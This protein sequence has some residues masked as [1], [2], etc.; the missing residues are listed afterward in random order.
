MRLHACCNIHRCA[1][2]P[3]ALENV[4]AAVEGGFVRLIVCQGNSNVCCV[5]NKADAKVAL[6]QESALC[7]TPDTPT[8]ASRTCQMF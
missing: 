5:A 1:A 2:G 3:G 6:P 4:R 7:M 8:E